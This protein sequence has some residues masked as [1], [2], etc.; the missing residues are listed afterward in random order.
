MRRCDVRAG[1]FKPSVTLGLSVLALVSATA[2][3]PVGPA[4]IAIGRSDDG[5]EVYVTACRNDVSSVQLVEF[6]ESGRILS[7]DRT[8]PNA[9]WQIDADEPVDVEHL[10]V[11]GQRPTGFREVRALSPGQGV[12]DLSVVVYFG[13]DRARADEMTV[14][15]PPLDPGVVLDSRGDEVRV[16]DFLGCE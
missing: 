15:D 8:A 13:D 2:C 10:T 1:R 3:D 9:L 16:E 4:L 5:V 14:V 6:E 11:G 12:D 7:Y